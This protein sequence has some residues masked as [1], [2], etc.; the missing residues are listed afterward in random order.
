MS[1]GCRARCRFCS[2]PD[3]M[4][5][6]VRSRPVD[7]VF[8]EMEYLVTQRGVRHFEWLDDDLLFGRREFLSLLERIIRSGWGITWS[9]SN[10][11]IATSLDA[12]SLDKTLFHVPVG[13]DARIGTP[14]L[15]YALGPIHA[16]GIGLKQV[17]IQCPEGPIVAL[18]GISYPHSGYSDHHIAQIAPG[19]AIQEVQPPIRVIYEVLGHIRC[20]RL[21]DIRHRQEILGQSPDLSLGEIHRHTLG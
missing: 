21:F 4:G 17:P 6:G 10:G 14:D 5:R 7:A 3:F 2:V 16:T 1:R 20:L 8:A 19:T 13:M 11:L 18:P 12:D 9:A 15:G